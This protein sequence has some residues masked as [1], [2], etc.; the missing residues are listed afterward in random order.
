[1]PS[2]LPWIA[3]PTWGLVLLLAQLRWPLRAWRGRLLPRLALNAAVAAFAFALAALAVRPAARWA[4]DDAPLA[5]G[6]LGLV[7]W[8]SWVELAAAMLLMDLSFYWWHRAN[9]RIPLL[10]RFHNVHHCDPELDVT[11]A[12]R[13]HPGEVLASVAFRVLQVAVIGIEPLAF[14]AYELCFQAAVLFHHSNW[15]LTPRWDA[16]L[17]WL[18]VTPRMHGSHHSQRRV[19][20]DANYGVVLSIWDRL[21][22][23]FV[24]A[25]ERELRIGVPGYAEPEDNRLGALLV[26]PLRRQRDHWGEAG[27]GPCG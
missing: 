12:L 9:H 3:V 16:V 14:A 1:M 21:H 27:E 8:P 23:S 5:G 24:M 17:R 11:T 22:R 19:E 2:W 7:A 26:M 13:F 18:V 4:M 10:W 15:R 20:A 6:L 25:D